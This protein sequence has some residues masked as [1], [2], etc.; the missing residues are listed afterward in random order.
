MYRYLTNCISADGESIADMVD[1]E[2]QVTWD[3]FTRHVP[4]SDLEDMFPQYSWHGE[5]GL[6]LKD[7]WAVS[8]WK[9]KY[10]GRDCYFMN[11]SAIEY[12]WVR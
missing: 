5:R 8:F 10:Q 4:L 3:E 9:S 2:Q 12:I 7:D 6:L 1:Q 11:H